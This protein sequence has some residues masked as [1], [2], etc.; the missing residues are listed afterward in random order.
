MGTYLSIFWDAVTRLHEYSKANPWKFYSAYLVFVI[1]L[2]SA[3]H[4]ISG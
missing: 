3:A 2:V 1:C 4:Y